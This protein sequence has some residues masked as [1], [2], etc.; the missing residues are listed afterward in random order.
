MEYY[1][2]IKKE[3]NLAICSNV[4]GSRGYNAKYKSVSD[5]CHM[6]SGTYGILFVLLFLREKA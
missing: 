4:D 1:L 3:W 6:I 2:A 5:K